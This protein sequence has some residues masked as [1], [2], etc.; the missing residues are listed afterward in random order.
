M[1]YKLIGAM[2]VILAC[3]GVGF[4]MATQYVMQIRALADTIAVI[5][6]ME[7]EIQYRCTPLPALCRQ[8]AAQVSGRL[9]LVFAGLADELEAQ[10][11]PNV[12]LCMISVLDKLNITCESIREILLR[13][14][15]NLGNFDMV[16]QL[17]ALENARNLC[18]EDLKQL[19]QGKR[20]RIRSYQTLGLCAGAAIAILLV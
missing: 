2:C 18:R 8:A 10:V 3:G 7:S 13:L 12:E 6:Y 4:M 9:H 15:Y 14:S 5:N 17:K 11:A 20:E 16:G 1:N 19:Q